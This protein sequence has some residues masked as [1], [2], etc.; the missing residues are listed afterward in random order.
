MSSPPRALSARDAAAERWIAL[1]GVWLVALTAWASWR[2]L[3]P[4]APAPTSAPADEFSATRAFAHVQ[5]LATAP[6][7]AGSAAHAR[8]RRYILQELAARGLETS[9]QETTAVDPTDDGRWIAMRVR[10]VLGRLPGTGSGPAVLLASHYDSQP[11][12]FGAGDAASGVAVLLETLRALVTGQPPARDVRV[13]ITDGEEV[14]LMG[15]RAFVAEPP[16]GGEIGLVLNF[17]ARGNRGPVP[18]FETASGN[19]DLMRAYRDVTPLPFANSF[20]FEV[21][22]RMPNDTD[23]SVFKRAGIPGLNFAFIGGYP[24]Y[25]SMLDA[26]GRLALASVQQEGENALALVRRF[27][28]GPLPTAATRDAVYFNPWGRA[29]VLYDGRWAP[30]VAGVLVLAVGLGFA[31]VV[32]SGR[33]GAGRDLARAVGLWLLGV[34]ASL[35]LGWMFW[36]VLCVLPGDLLRGPYGLPYDHRGFVVVFVLLVAALLCSLLEFLGGRWLGTLELAAASLLM[37]TAALLR[38]TWGITGASYLAAWP[39]L[40]SLPVLLWA[41]R[42]ARRPGVLLAAWGLAALP[43]VALWAPVVDLTFQALTLEQAALVAA[44]TALAV[45]LVWPLLGALTRAW[46]WRPAAALAVAALALGTWLWLRDAPSPERPR[47][48][49]LFWVETDLGVGEGDTGDGWWSLDEAADEWTRG[50]LGEA[51][52]RHELPAVLA[53]DREGLSAPAE[54]LGLE[55]PVVQVLADQPQGNGRRLR[56]GLRSPRGGEV[57]RLLVDAPGGLASAAVDGR[58]LQ[59][60]PGERLVLVYHAVPAAGF[61]LEL[62]TVSSARPT[63]TLAD[64]S[65]GLPPARRGLVGER[66]SDTIPRPGW[67]TDSTFVLRRMAL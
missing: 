2:A 10:N 25:H 16:H 63:L 12:T 17:E 32:V 39:M 6:R 56:I 50:A 64:Q 65:Y 58:P 54:A 47:V 19:L 27:A 55:P 34:V 42:R 60:A 43:G 24:A 21:Y 53:L 61:E 36:A 62:V 5:A 26:P 38:L 35:G 9:I 49:T 33:E 14:D 4:P 23:Y 40:F 48:D 46:R 57:M 66:P 7:P 31:R 67:L 41:A 37:W 51:P 3:E 13:L 1:A 59:T 20:S 52:E 30:W 29:F 44:P 8:A 11:Q 22:Q 15:A 18:M 45:T 28:H